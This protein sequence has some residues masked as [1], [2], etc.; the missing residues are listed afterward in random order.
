MVEQRT[1][2]PRVRG[3]NPRLGTAFYF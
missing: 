1:E 2:N 3:S